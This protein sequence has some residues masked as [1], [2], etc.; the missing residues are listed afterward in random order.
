MISVHPVFLAVPL[1]LC[2]GSFAW[3]MGRFFVH[4]E[5]LPA[6]LKITSIVGLISA[7]AN[8]A[9]IMTSQPTIAQCL[10]GGALYSL[11]ILLFWW[12][13]AANLQRPLAACFTGICP[14]H[15][16]MTGPYGWV[17]HPFYC[18]YLLAGLAGFAGTGNLWLLP[19]SALMA[20]IY[21]VAAVREE[22]QFSSGPLA[23]EYERYRNRT[24]MFFP[25][26]GSRAVE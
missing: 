20:A 9:A 21:F 6:G 17:R 12:A 5:T 13:V 22:K 1:V 15:L 11:A 3:G 10:M 18:S 19:I 24:G 8:T 14:T 7:S 26:P 25:M 23:D 2:L 16:T 4:Q